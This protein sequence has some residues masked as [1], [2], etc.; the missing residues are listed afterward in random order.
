MPH[1]V[2]MDPED[3]STFVFVSGDLM[4]RDLSSIDVPERGSLPFDSREVLSRLDQE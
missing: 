1:I 2:Q 3:R 4:R